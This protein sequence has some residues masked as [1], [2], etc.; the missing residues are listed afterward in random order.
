M[1]A[2][3]DESN[4]E[5]SETTAGIE[6]KAFEHWYSGGNHGCRIIERSG[7]TYKLIDARRAWRAWQAAA[8]RAQAH[9]ARCNE[10]NMRKQLAEIKKE[11]DRLRAAIQQTL[12]ENGH[13]ADGENCTLIVLKRALKTLNV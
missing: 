4:L 13:L 1:S 11:R 5:E 7:S 6:R 9:A 8:A 10:N 12:D 2:A 3:N